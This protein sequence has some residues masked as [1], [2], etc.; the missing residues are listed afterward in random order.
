VIISLYLTKFGRWRSN[1][2]GDRRARLYRG[3]EN[4][5]IFHVSRY[6]SVTVQDSPISDDY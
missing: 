5:T 3:L 4:F 1:S 2:S 6:I